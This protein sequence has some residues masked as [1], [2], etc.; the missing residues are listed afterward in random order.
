[1]VITEY[2]FTADIEQ[3]VRFVMVSD[4]HGCD[5]NP[6]IENINALCP[7]AILIPGDVIHND[8]N[9]KRGIEFLYLCGKQ[10]PIFM[11]LG[12]HE[13]KFSGDIIAEINNTGAC[14]L[15]NSYVEFKGVKIGGLTTGY[16][17]GIG[18][19]RFKKTPPPDMEWVEEF[20]GLEGYKI[21]L[22]HHPEYYK[23]LLKDKNVSLILSGHAHGGQWRIFGRGIFAP[24]QGIF[25]KYTSGLYD[26]KMIVG[27]GLG[28]P[29]AIPRINN[30]P[31]IIVI[32]IVKEG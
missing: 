10:Y 20:S 24:G 31:E 14:L 15:D 4:L 26:G 18:Q 25:P 16:A 19:G 23:P 13:N 7:D 8:K 5:N 22:S 27:R 17:K 28:N 1:M 9:Y 30:K 32:D 21:L 3:N 6:I 2:K 29:H 12:N 11:S